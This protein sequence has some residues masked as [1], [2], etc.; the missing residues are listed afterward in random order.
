MNLKTLKL[1]IAFQL[2]EIFTLLENQKK[3]C[4]PKEHG[5]TVADHSSYKASP[6]LQELETLTSEET[7]LLLIALS[8]MSES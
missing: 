5:L 1:F 4:A 7:H 2:L 3:Q 6:G 8:L